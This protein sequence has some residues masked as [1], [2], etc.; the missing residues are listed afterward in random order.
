SLASPREG[1]A[2]CRQLA[3]RHRFFILS[4]RSRLAHEPM[5]VIFTISN[6]KTRGG[7]DE[8]ISKPGCK[9]NR[10]TIEVN[11][12][13]CDSWALAGWRSRRARHERASPPGHEC[14]TQR[15]VRDCSGLGERSIGKISAP[16]RM[17]K[18]QERQS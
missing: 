11:L 8:R 6:K 10:R 4:Q 9:C 13:S 2:R 14:G 3:W 12:G 5:F 1:S 18:N 15:R 7:T 17:G 16:S